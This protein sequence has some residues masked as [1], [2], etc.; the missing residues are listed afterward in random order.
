MKIHKVCKNV[1]VLVVLVKIG[2]DNFTLGYN[3]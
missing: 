3:E 2:L 1:S